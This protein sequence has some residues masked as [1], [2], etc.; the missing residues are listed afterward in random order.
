MISIPLRDV[1]LIVL[2]MTKTSTF[3]HWKCRRFSHFKQTPNS[4]PIIRVGFIVIR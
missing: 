1:F 3:Q 4:Y 2:K